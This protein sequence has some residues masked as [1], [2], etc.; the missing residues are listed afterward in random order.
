[1]RALTHWFINKLIQRISTEMSLTARHRARRCIHNDSHELVLSPRCSRPGGRETDIKR[2]ITMDSVSDTM[3]VGT[4]CSWEL[5][6]GQGVGESFLQEL[7]PKL[8]PGSNAS[9]WEWTS[10]NWFR[11]LQGSWLNFWWSLRVIFALCFVASLG[12]CPYHQRHGWWYKQD[13]LN[14]ASM[15]LRR[16]TL[17]TLSYFIF[18]TTLKFQYWRKLRFGEFEWLAQGF[19]A[20]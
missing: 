19:T 6:E 4:R 18:I 17:C 11:W 15:C 10:G 9:L 16:S 7:R 12:H 20:K 14:T 2:T 8:S 3:E 5:R 1:M 13:C